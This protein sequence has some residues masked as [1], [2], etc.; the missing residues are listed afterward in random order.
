MRANPS[1]KR[2]EDPALRRPPTQL[3]AVL[4]VADEL[5][6]RFQAAG[7]ELFLV[8][9]SVRDALL[10][11]LGN[12]LDFTTDARPQ[13][14]LELLSGWAQATWTIGI[15]YGTVGAR[16]AGYTLEITT[17]RADAYRR[18]SRKPEVEF[19]D[20]LQ[21]DLQ[22]RD[23]A[24]NAMAVPL[25]SS[26]RRPLVDPFG[27]LDDLAARRLRTPADPA[28]SFTDDPLR[29]LRGAR[30]R[31][32]LAFDLDPAALA[33]LRELRD[34][35]DIVSRE[36]IRDEL[37]KL[38][39]AEYPR[40]GLTVLVD[41]GMAE[42]VL[43]ELPKLR[44]EIDEHHHHKDVYEHTLTV[45]D[46]A[47]AL[48]PA[49]PDLPLRWAALLHD[50]GKPKTRALGPGGRVSFH[51]HEVVGAAMARS[52]L[53][54]LRYPKELVEQ[55][56]RLVEL[57]LR[58]HGYAAG[59]W[60]D[61]AVRRYVR[62]AGPELSRLHLLVRSDCTTRNRRKA[63][64]LAAAYDSL[65]ARIDELGKQEELARIRPDLDGLAVMEILAVPAGPIVGRALRF[66]TDLRIERGPLGRQAATEALLEWARAQGDALP[67]PPAAPTAPV[68]GTEE[69]PE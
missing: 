10:G 1:P 23:F 14:I 49:G 24:V 40:L 3:A 7:H 58:F 30:F 8:G 19:G 43:P 53:E 11:R 69:L 21:A 68:Q 5:G 6:A 65:E 59:E 62:D 31:A 26:G 15:D 13:R 44:L 64:A 28:M 60:T 56:S 36:R 47:I 18:D 4:P 51:H 48:E 32:Q 2:A 33:A 41:S 52:R 67:G 17:F 45:L 35:I 46:Q 20:S 12:D 57:H 37:T 63:A 55:V 42:R 27:G 29:M 34:R 66:L 54:S 39:L 61:A 9:G 50:I 25:P 16:K 38:L 22:R